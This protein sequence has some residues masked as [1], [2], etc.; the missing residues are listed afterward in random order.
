M[1]FPEH[2]SLTAYQQLLALASNFCIRESC[3]YQLLHKM[4]RKA[5]I[6]SETSQADNTCPKIWIANRGYSEYKPDLKTGRLRNAVVILYHK[7]YCMEVASYQHPLLTIGGILGTLLTQS[8][9]MNLK[10]FV[11][12]DISS[13]IPDDKYEEWMDEEGASV[14][15]E[16]K[17]SKPVCRV[18]EKMLLLNATVVAF[19]TCCQLLLKV[20]PTVT[21]S[22]DAGHKLNLENVSRLIFVD[23]VLP[24]R[25]IN[26]QLLG[27]PSAFA[28]N[29]HSDFVFKSESERDR[30]LSILRSCFLKGEC[31][32]K[33]AATFQESLISILCQSPAN[34][35]SA[36]VD[37]GTNLIDLDATNSVGETVWMSEMTIVMNR[38]SKQYEQI[39]TDLTRNMR[40][41]FIENKKKSRQQANSLIKQSGAG[42]EMR[43][44]TTTV[45]SSAVN[46]VT[47][48][49]SDE[50]GG[51]VLRGNRCVLVR[52]LENLWEGMKIPSVPALINEK[53]EETAI[54]AVSELCDID[55]DE[56]YVLA[57]IPPSVIYYPAVPGSNAYNISVYVMYAIQPPPDGALEEQ[58]KED[59]DDLYDWY[60]WQ[61][62]VDAFTSVRNE[63]SI[64]TMRSIACSLAA[65]SACAGCD[66]IPRKWGG[67]FGQEW[68]HPM[69]NGGQSTER[70][71]E[72][73][74][75]KK[76]TTISVKM[77]ILIIT[78]AFGSG[79]SNLSQ[80]L[81]V[82]QGVAAKVALIINSLGNVNLD[83]ALFKQS[84][85]DDEWYTYKLFEINGYDVSYS[86]EKEMLNLVQKLSKS[87]EYD[88]C[89]IEAAGTANLES[90]ISILSEE[91]GTDCPYY[92]DST[93]CVV[94]AVNSLRSLKTRMSS[95]PSIGIEGLQD[96]LICKQIR[97]STVI[98]IN[99][100]DQLPKGAARIRNITEIKS[101]IR[102][103]N[104]HADIV[105]STF[106]DVNP[107]TLMYT[108]RLIIAANHDLSYV[109]GLITSKPNISILTFRA[110]RPFHPMRFD[111]VMREMGIS[112]ENGKLLV[113]QSDVILRINGFM[114]MANYPDNQCLLSYTKG[115]VYE[116]NLGT[117]WWATVEKRLWPV[118]L[119]DAIR[120][121]WLEPYGDRQIE[122]TLF[123]FLFDPEVRC[124]IEGVL[125][126]CLLTDEEFGLG[127][128]SWNEMD[129]PFS[130][131]FV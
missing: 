74:S 123:G 72:L 36:K 29:V 35:E 42:A 21:N 61:R 50:V 24:S 55:S 91:G 28:A 6:I 92:I 3:I 87:G 15:L 102:Q 97:A 10:N 71:G 127:Q 117:Q 80:Y 32:V 70:S 113:P 107:S 25:C 41:L 106:G 114:W 94:D 65:A 93:V 31:F 110:K 116:S 18:L 104:Q 53:P 51:L 77:P 100:C 119:E 122:L 67:I 68:I 54:R 73:K 101:A 40:D 112:G 13:L 14:H 103:L 1:I 130:Y 19:G 78:G 105:E 8:E 124:A 90:L 128:S 12:V 82:N 30:R 33:P 5:R 57:S 98:V 46:S 81:L 86:S 64:L 39:A 26:A 4:S 20:I 96:S 75:G 121:L 9:Q 83:G 126:S 44:K 34:D 84:G 59:V 85:E 27:T 48:I 129:D 118:G 89:V 45:S 79:K 109:Q 60:T 58:D 125:S 63:S 76:S 38:N 131:T 23:P 88:Y 115:H 52:S 11:L 17:I 2:I 62:A 47:K 99:R 111:T 69:K 22:S 49:R 66:Y 120:P 95:H 7:S 43:N 108:R 37:C 56:F 16:K